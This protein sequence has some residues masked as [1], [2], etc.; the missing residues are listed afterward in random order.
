M[1]TISFPETELTSEEW[2]E[3]TVRTTAYIRQRVEALKDIDNGD[4]LRT[5]LKIPYLQL[6]VPDVDW[7]TML[8]E[9]QKL[10]SHF[11]P[12]RSSDSRGWK[13]LCLHGIEAD[14][15][16]S[17][18]RYG[19]AN[20]QATPYKWTWAAEAAP[21]TTAW[22]KRLKDDGYFQE[23]YRIR[24]MWLEPEG[25]IRFHRDRPEEQN[26][27]GPMNVA[28]NMPEGCHWIF[29]AWGFLPFQ[30]GSA[31]AVDVSNLHAVS[32][33]SG[34]DRVHLIVH[35]KYGP[36]Y[37]RAIT[38]AARRLR[39]S[40]LPQMPALLK[41]D[42]SFQL[43]LWRYSPGATVAGLEEKWFGLTHH[44]IKL[45]SSGE[46]NPLEHYS[47]RRILSETLK[48][49]KQWAV[50]MTPG[51]VLKEGF[52]SALR[53]TLSEAGPTTAVIGH[54]LDRGPRGYGLHHQMLLVDVLKWKQMGQPTLGAPGEN[55]LCQN[56]GQRSS[57][58]VHDDY[59]PRFI[60]PGGDTR[61]VQDTVCGWRMID[62]ALAKGYSVVNLPDHLR[63]AKSFLYPDQ[64]GEAL[65]RA[66]DGLSSYETER[67]PVLSQTQI[68]TLQFLRVEAVDFA[69]KVFIFNTEGTFEFQQ[70]NRGVPLD[71][72]YTLSAGFK[73][74]AILRHH[75]FHPETEITYF[76]ICDASLFMKQVA[77]RE[78]DG[79]NYPEFIR[80]IINDHPE[81]FQSVR[82]T[83]DYNHLEGPWERELATWGGAEDFARFFARVRQLKARFVNID[84]MKAP[85][86]I[87]KDLSER[88]R[89]N[90]AIWYSNCFN[91]TPTLARH[92]WSVQTMNTLGQRFLES[93]LE[94]SVRKKSRVYM[95]GED[96]HSGTKAP[97]T[98]DLITSYFF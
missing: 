89:G 39:E 55:G 69:R 15:T 24:Y 3:L 1:E 88:G 95:Y 13:S 73:E 80:R 46:L 65:L 50:V 28:L 41:N 87:S 48:R 60:L 2:R 31:M 77:L 44:F 85:E 12:H 18:D 93:I 43:G 74:L 35:G 4:R 30:P 19:F 54:L 42:G 32:N 59:T 76:D 75:G 62:T 9:A 25:F 34:I 38:S 72:L 8:V 45:K 86:W 20:E 61:T 56:V 16:L 83:A 36:A 81:V 14:Q 71:H 66:I 84:L 5:E 91:Y 64:N 6:P 68:E 98:G 7:A 37:S 26:S 23:Y 10:E 70:K 63:A 97:H 27:L 11:V 57:E 82:I 58:N 52:F 29:K 22:L 94:T 21:V 49:G 40:P 79:R 67:F 78:W 47:L 92:G 51:T 90:Q 53:K 17:C 96:I 33:R